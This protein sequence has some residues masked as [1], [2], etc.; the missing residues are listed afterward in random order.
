MALTLSPTRIDNNLYSST[1]K[2]REPMPP[3]TLTTLLSI[4]IST[5]VFIFTTPTLALPSP[6][7]T[8][9]GSLIFPE[10]DQQCVKMSCPDQF[11]TG[12]TYCRSLNRGCLFCAPNPRSLMPFVT[13][14]CI[15]HWEVE[16]PWGGFGVSNG[17]ASR[18]TI[19]NEFDGETAAR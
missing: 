13:F 5:F 7:R 17:S 19:W 12:A 1:S 10:A 16:R 18:S 3:T 4:S 9:T 15:G 11:H 14:A 2:P 8:P 6:P